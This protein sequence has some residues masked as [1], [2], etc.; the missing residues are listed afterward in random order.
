MN[1]C[2]VLYTQWPNNDVIR[3]LPSPQ[4][5]LGI[6]PVYIYRRRKIKGERRFVRLRHPPKAAA[7]T[8]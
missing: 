4:F 2:V 8:T 7:T 1:A 6:L 3:A 5:T